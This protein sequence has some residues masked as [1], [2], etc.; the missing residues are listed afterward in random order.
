MSQT[1]TMLRNLPPA[2]RA[3]IQVMDGSRDRAALLASLIEKAREESMVVEN[4]QSTSE[5][6]TAVEFI[7]QNFDDMLDEIARAALLVA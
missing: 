7:E 2:M 6:E 3:L 4:E 5:A 1:H